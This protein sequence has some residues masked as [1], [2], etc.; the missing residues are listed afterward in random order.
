MNN[1]RNAWLCIALL[2]A[3]GTLGLLVFCGAT[4]WHLIAWPLLV[5]FAVLVFGGMCY[6]AGRADDVTR[7]VMGREDERMGRK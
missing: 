6:A 4:G 7:R 2:Y 1:P 5:G 3:A